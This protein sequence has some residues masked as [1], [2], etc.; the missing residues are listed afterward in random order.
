MPLPLIIPAALALALA[1]ALTPSSSRAL[2]L[3][4]IRTD[5]ALHEPFLGHIE[6]Y[7]L[8]AEEL[9]AVKVNLAPEAEF[10]KAGSPRPQFLT[11]LTFIPEV[12]AG[13]RVQVRVSSPEPIR[14]PY[15]DFLVEV[16]WPKGRLVKGYTV[17]LDPPA[18][19]KRPPSTSGPPRLAAASPPPVPV[20]A[21]GAA[22]SIAAA[23]PAR[24]TATQAPAAPASA[25][26]R[27]IPAG[28]EGEGSLRPMGPELARVEREILLVR[29][30]MAAGQ[31]ATTELRERVSHLEER[32]ADIKRLQDLSNAQ[33]A[34]LQAGAMVSLPAVGLSGPLAG[35]SARVNADDAGRRGNLP[36]Q[37]EGTSAGAQGELGPGLAAPALLRDA[38]PAPR[39]VP[40]VAPQLA[41]S[42]ILAAVTASEP[43]SSILVEDKPTANPPAMTEPGPET[44]SPVRRPSS[45]NLA[46]PPSPG[47]PSLF[48]T[49]LS[50]PLVAA[51]PLLILLLVTLFARRRWQE[52]QATKDLPVAAPAGT[53]RTGESFP[54]PSLDPEPFAPL[55]PPLPPLAPAKAPAGV[56]SA[57]MDVL[58]T[59]AAPKPPCAIAPQ[60]GPPAPAEGEG[61]SSLELGMLE[62]LVVEPLPAVPAPEAQGARLAGPTQPSLA[63]DLDFD[64]LMDTS[65]STPVA[66]EGQG[67]REGFLAPAPMA[68]DPGWKDLEIRLETTMAE[69][70]SPPRAGAEVPRPLDPGPGTEYREDLGMGHASWDEV[71]TKLRLARA[72]LQL[73]DPVAARSILNEA[74]AEGSDEQIAEAK[75]L[76]ARLA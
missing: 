23:G 46:L 13:D 55:S 30:M 14:E 38:E 22:P 15:L 16:T 70:A 5:S 43:E 2:G 57:V 41:A 72:Y 47:E 40:A 56:E 44:S 61:K 8:T 54:S 6:V 12:A 51:G 67:R 65:L 9:D 34:Q 27:L 19:S 62:W 49:W 11:R 69:A 53:G 71:G 50:W 7:D 58:A 48:D 18:T 21:S 36:T 74:L 42:S 73:D 68:T 37:H 1:L 17:L 24:P 33:L 31:A 45:S 64:G 60:A 10:T 4:G 32:L 63:L 35:P 39:P 52:A 25:V 75:A 20:E 3:G 59:D 28:P 66:G 76:L 26:S 29:E